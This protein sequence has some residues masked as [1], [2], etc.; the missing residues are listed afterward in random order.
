MKNKETSQETPEKVKN[1]KLYIIIAAAG[2][3]V[4]AGLIVLSVLLATRDGAVNLEKPDP[5]VE[6][7][8]DGDEQ[9]DDGDEQPDGEE[10]APS[11]SETVFTLPVS[12]G[13]VTA[14]FSFWYNSTLDRYN[15]HEGI[16]FRADA[17]TDVAAASA[18]TVAA[19]TDTLL[20]GGCIVID[21]GDGLQTVY[22]SVDAVQGLQVGDT[23]SAGDIIAA[24]SA[25]A[26]VMGT[27]Y[28]EGAHLHF[29]VQ[30]DGKAVDPAAYLDLDEK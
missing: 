5:G 15:L 6:Q 20:E 26:D 28:N 11:G 24:V 18:G 3:L 19:I 25:A 16:D 9:P 30:K 4:L 12:G 23:V 27:E 14:T 22:A 7:P 21:H 8:D 17:G 2:A 29:E 13:T 10:D 1:K